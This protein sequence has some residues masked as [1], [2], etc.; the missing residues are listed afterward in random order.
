MI[1]TMEARTHVPDVQASDCSMI[2]RRRARHF[3]A[4]ACARRMAVSGRRIGGSA[5]SIHAAMCPVPSRGECAGRPAEQAVRL[6]PSACQRALSQRRGHRAH[7]GSGWTG[8]Q[9]RPPRRAS[10]LPL[11]RLKI[12]PFLSWRASK[13]SSAVERRPRNE[14]ARDLRRDHLQGQTGAGPPDHRR[15]EPRRSPSPYREQAE[16]HDRHPAPRGLRLAR[17]VWAALATA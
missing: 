13:P 15:H 8:H 1:S 6:V 9:D 17:C 12:S 5:V 4:S 3:T 7:C 11:P 16:G 10:G 2:Q 14:V